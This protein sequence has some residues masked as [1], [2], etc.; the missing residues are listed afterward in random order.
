MKLKQSPVLLAAHGK[1]EQAANGT[2]FIDEVGALPPVL[3]SKLVRYS[4]TAVRA[5]GGVESLARINVIATSTQPLDSLVQQE[6]FDR[7]CITCSTHSR[8]ICRRSASGR[9][10]SLLVDHFVKH[11][12]ASRTSTRGGSVSRSIGVADHV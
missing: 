12:A 3:Q 7:T 4:P 5:T 2:L 6:H 8:S 9:R 1:V 10:H 11:L